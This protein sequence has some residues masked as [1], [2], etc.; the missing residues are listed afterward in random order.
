[1]TVATFDVIDAPAASVNV[2]LV[3]KAK[4]AGPLPP[5]SVT[6]AFVI[7]TEPVLTTST[8]S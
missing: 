6:W 2:L 8:R 5:T 7:A 1:M 3:P 4:L